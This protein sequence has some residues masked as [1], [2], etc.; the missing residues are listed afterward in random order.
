MLTINESVQVLLSDKAVVIRRFYDRFLAE[1]PEA[2]PYFDDVKL[3]HQASLLTIALVTM[4]THYSH[5]YPATEHYLKV[6]GYRHRDNGIPPQLFPRFGESLI[7]TLKEY[8]GADWND[9][10]E[11]QWNEAFAKTTATM[12]EGYEMEFTY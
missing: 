3:E 12:L 9:G 10:L 8:H 1:C 2:R 5:S 7:A 11:L 6:L 4:E